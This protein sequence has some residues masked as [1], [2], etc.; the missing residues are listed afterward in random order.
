MGQ[1]AFPY[2][3]RGKRCCDHGKRTTGYIFWVAATSR[4]RQQTG[5]HKQHPAPPV[6]THKKKNRHST[7]IRAR[8]HKSLLRLATHEWTQVKGKT[9][10]VFQVSLVEN[11]RAGFSVVLINLSNSTPRTT[12]RKSCEPAPAFTCSR[13]WLLF[14]AWPCQWRCW[15]IDFFKKGTCAFCSLWARVRGKRRGHGQTSLWHAASKCDLRCM[16]RPPLGT[17]PSLPLGCDRGASLNFQ[18]AWTLR[19]TESTSKIGSTFKGG[20]Q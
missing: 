17:S 3:C 12:I 20:V 7:V 15:T 18:L 4:L 9:Q 5:K 2:P 11:R 16:A 1:A 19:F 6:Y 13:I 10:M 14:P 8:P